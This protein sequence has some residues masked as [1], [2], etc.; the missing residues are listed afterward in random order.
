MGKVGAQLIIFAYNSIIIDE[1]LQQFFYIYKRV[2][3]VYDLNKL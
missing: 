1:L 3:Y 2:T